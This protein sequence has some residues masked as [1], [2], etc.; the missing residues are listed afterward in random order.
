MPALAQEA[1]TG[2]APAPDP[3]E[4]PSADPQQEESAAG[5]REI[6]T[7]ADFARYAPRNA[8]DMLREVPGF[9][10]QGEDRERGLGT[11][12][13]NILIN[14]ERF[15]SKST[16]ARDQL[17]R[18]PADS[19]VRI[20][21]VD[22]ATLDIPGLRGRVANIVSNT[23][24]GGL[25]GQFRWQPQF[26][27]GPANPRLTQGEV[28]VSGARGPVDFTIALANDNFYG[29]SQGDVTIVDA[30]GV[31]DR[32]VNKEKGFSN[33]PRLSG[34]FRV[35]LGGDA[36]ATLNLSYNRHW[37]DQEE[38]EYRVGSALPRLS[39]AFDSSNRRR[40]YEIGGEVVFGVGPGR[41]KLIALDT[42][43]TSDF[44]TEALFLRAGQADAGTRFTRMSDEGERIGRAEYNWA[45][46]GGD[47][48]LSGEAAFNRL[49][50]ESALAVLDESGAFIDVPFPGASGGVRE[51]RYQAV[52][53]YG[54][55]LTDR[56]SMQVTAGGEYSTIA[57]TG[58]AALSRTFK[59]PKGSLALAWAASDTLDLNLSLARKVGQLDFDDFLASVNLSDDNQNAGN[60]ELR[61]EQSWDVELEA[62][63][64][65]GEWGS[66]TLTG[67]ARRIT[68]FITIIPVGDAG[69][70]SRGNI[71]S[72][73]AYGAR[74]SATVQLVPMGFT[75][76]KLDVEALWEE[77]D[78]L[79]PVTGFSRRFDGDKYREIELELR[80][81]VPGSDWAWGAEYRRTKFGN[82][83]R[84]AEFGFDYRVPQFGAVYLEHK[85]VWGMTVK[86]RLGNL[87]DS[88]SLL[89][90]EVFA[91]PRS[92]GVLLFTE[93][94]F[95]KIGLVAEFAVSGSF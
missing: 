28:S 2:D 55:V 40:E 14:G 58:S 36:S 65:F 93:D 86:G 64:D 31:V 35:G 32:R 30:L 37:F 27:T 33:S 45:M 95:R 18:I 26:S 12:S 61:P 21:I 46:L 1:E 23:T 89:R 50:Q 69:G 10:I 41:L 70:E 42:A 62:T 39:D 57:Q 11:A 6:F 83:Y 15:T 88:G 60:N 90:R 78:L 19:V 53:S 54:R 75:G 52:L 85:D 68:D 87:F 91:G 48:Q 44:T 92:D 9:Q 7:P 76:A 43:Q 56:L 49:D 94:R 66:A 8:L 74:L 73:E 34:V 22:G 82:Y 47:W 13:G 25:A 81:D 38:F 72:A 59:R 4:V 77:S 80:Q 16:S 84:V 63:R 71:D 79:D 24:G 67:F 20:E 51:D 3:V 29:G 5:D 17:S